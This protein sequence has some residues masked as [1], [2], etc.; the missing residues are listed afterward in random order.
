MGFENS[1]VDQS[2]QTKKSHSDIKYESHS[3][4]FKNLKSKQLTDNENKQISDF[5]S[6]DLKSDSSPSTLES[7]SLIIAN[8]KI[9]NSD[10]CNTTNPNKSLSSSLGQFNYSDSPHLFSSASQPPSNFMSTSRSIHDNY[11]DDFKAISTSP[12]SL[13]YHQ[14]KNENLN[15]NYVDKNTTR[16]Q[17]NFKEKNS[18]YSGIYSKNCLDDYSGEKSL[19]D[20][21][22]TYVKDCEVFLTNIFCFFDLQKESDSSDAIVGSERCEEVEEKQNKKYTTEMDTSSNQENIIETLLNNITKYEIDLS[23]KIEFMNNV[24]DSHTSKNATSFEPPN[25]S[26]S[27]NMDN[28]TNIVQDCFKTLDI[29]RDNYLTIID[30]T[31]HMDDKVTYMDRQMMEKRDDNHED[32]DEEE[33]KEIEEEGG[34]EEKEDEK[35]RNITDVFHSNEDITMEDYGTE[36]V[37]LDQLTIANSLSIFSNKDYHSR[38]MVS[39]IV[40]VVVY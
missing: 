1:S 20:I 23:T 33:T 24:S 38:K 27:L 6:L 37:S 5:I 14:G 30:F 39:N 31:D 3:I 26:Y 17:S 40:L 9:N 36:K 10:I 8:S 32:E 15:E 25:R 35:I 2:S 18:D 12:T 16:E 11:C 34:R 7:S 13:N 19:S 21:V 28:Y 22:S 4:D 29:D